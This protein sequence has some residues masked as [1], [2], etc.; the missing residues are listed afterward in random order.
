MTLTD[1]LFTALISSLVSIV[2]VIIN[3]KNDKKRYLDIQ[4]DEIIKI[5]IQY[6]YVEDPEFISTWLSSDKR[7]EKYLRYE[8]YC[9]LV[10]NYMER[11]C[12][13]YKFNELNIQA[14]VNIKAWIRI[15]KDCW[16]HPSTPFEN[17]DSYSPELKSF[18]NKFL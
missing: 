13:F 9:N 7:D 3:N 11:F 1:G 5:S 4:L 12:A 10:F 2:I 14:R 16:L 17:S 8:N 6:P 15:H 18:L